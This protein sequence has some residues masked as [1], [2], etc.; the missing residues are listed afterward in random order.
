[1][2]KPSIRLAHT[3]RAG[4]RRSAGRRGEDAALDYLRRQGLELLERNY[5]SNGGE[6]DLVMREP[7]RGGGMAGLVFVEVRQR[8]SARFGGAAVSV[9]A[10]KQRRLILAAQHYLLRHAHPP[11]CRFDVVAIEGAQLHWLRDAF[12]V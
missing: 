3:L 10:A 1:M 6:I 8:A 12:G 7:A 9:T 4:L 5:R 11:P 2:E